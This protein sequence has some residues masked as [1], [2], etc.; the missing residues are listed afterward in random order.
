MNFHY[1]NLNPKKIRNSCQ[2]Q[3]TDFYS[4]QAIGYYFLILYHYIKNISHKKVNN[5]VIHDNSNSR[6]WLIPCLK[7][8]FLLRVDGFTLS[9]EL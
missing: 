1:T 8:L 9:I 2:K 4:P 5:N 7:L 6:C 3:G